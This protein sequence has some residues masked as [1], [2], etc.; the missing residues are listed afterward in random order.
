M[1]ET[2]KSAPQAKKILG[3]GAKILKITS[4]TYT[5]SGFLAPLWSGAPPLRY[6][7]ARSPS[8][9]PGDRV[10][11]G[12]WGGKTPHCVQRNGNVGLTM[13]RQNYSLSANLSIA[14]STQWKINVLY[15]WESNLPTEFEVGRVWH[16]SPYPDDTPLPYVPD[17]DYKKVVYIVI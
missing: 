4:T 12:V 14:F 15:V 6:A 10:P 17:Q 3:M 11:G 5:M 16:P 1:L 7:S 2:P 8:R 9:G 13:R